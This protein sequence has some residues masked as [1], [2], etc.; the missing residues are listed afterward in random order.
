MIKYE[1]HE[2]KVLM[3]NHAQLL[4]Q[5]SRTLAD[6]DRIPFIE[7]IEQKFVL[8]PAS[9]PFEYNGLFQ[10]KNARSLYVPAL[11]INSYLQKEDNYNILVCKKS[12][13]KG[14]STLQ[15][16]LIMYNILINPSSQLIF[17]PSLE[18]VT[19]WSQLK[20]TS[21]WDMMPDMVNYLGESNKLSTKKIRYPLGYLSLWT[22]F[23]TGA[24]QSSTA[25]Y[26]GIDEPSKVPVN[27]DKAGDTLN[28]LI[29]RTKRYKRYYIT[30]FGTPGEVAINN[31]II[32]NDNCM[33]SML[34]E[35]SNQ[36]TFHIYCPSC[37]KL[38][39]FPN[40]YNECVKRLKYTRKKL[41][42]KVADAGFTCEHCDYL[43]DDNIRLNWLMR[44]IDNPVYWLEKNPNSTGINGVSI[45]A[46]LDND[47]NSQEVSIN[48]IAS[49]FDETSSIPK[50]QA[51]MN[52][53]LAE[54]Y[55]FDKHIEE[56]K[57]DRINNLLTYNG[58]IPD[59][60]MLLTLGVD[61]Q[62]DRLECVVLGTDL[63]GSVYII[64][65]LKITGTVR[66]IVGRSVNAINTH[67][68][69]SVW[70]R[71]PILIK[72][73]YT[74]SSGLSLGINIT[75]IDGRNGNVT[76]IVNSF[77]SKYSSK[78]YIGFGVHYG[79]NYI[80]KMTGTG[81]AKTRK[82]NSVN[83]NTA[84]LL[85]RFIEKLTSDDVF[86]NDI[87]HDVIA[88]NI[89]HQVWDD[90]KKIFTNNSKWPLEVED[91]ICYALAGFEVSSL[92]SSVDITNFRMNHLTHIKNNVI[93]Y[94]NKEGI[95]TWSL[96]NLTGEDMTNLY[97]Y[98][99]KLKSKYN[100]NIDNKDIIEYIEKHI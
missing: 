52:L 83:V 87:Y 47:W 40:T 66:S 79:Y 19:E 1:E 64:E 32:N 100:K 80:V 59:T 65:H 75:I 17:F 73:K 71:L 24:G 16:A 93:E 25:N 92:I 53:V 69:D 67:H 90:K 88:T 68:D 77:V 3:S 48:A 74:T 96:E 14:Y 18:A 6:K 2:M 50:Q 21:S 7:W 9:T 22:L 5:L 12:A 8:P 98:I 54:A 82:A 57:S 99:L 58:N 45:N 72:K 62:E 34:W 10:F 27:I 97:V 44:H 63:V 38:T 30:V 61:V 41:N 91:C 70:K 26:I 11:A 13:Q 39:S 94:L 33:V 95:N 60:C 81:R 78:V 89:G 86:V 43:I 35:R 15:T 20:F 31:G 4:S 28:N 56:L 55:Y 85:F 29:A 76:N 46:F 37:K 23:Q 49:S 84:R 42:R 51:F 36:K